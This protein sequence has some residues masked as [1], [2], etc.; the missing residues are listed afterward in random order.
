M[1]ATAIILFGE[2]FT[3]VSHFA[4]ILSLK[5][6]GPTQFY[7]LQKDI[8]I[9]AIDR[10]NNLQ[11]NVIL[12]QLYG[13]ELILSGDGR[14]DSPGLSAKYCTYTFM[15]TATGAI[16]DFSLVQVS[17]TT[18]SPVMELL[19]FQRSLA[20]IEAVDLSV[21]VVVTD[22]MYK[23]VK[24]WEQTTAKRLTS[25]TSGICLSPLRRRS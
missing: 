12:Q 19:G 1:V 15:D 21:D 14:C 4:D 13:I 6:I 11:K 24:K 25:L 2:T 5:F 18:S 16:P 20:N 23:Y 17:E 9:P 8:A 3:R 22:R 7:S 10:F